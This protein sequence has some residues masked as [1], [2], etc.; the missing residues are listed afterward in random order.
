MGKPCVEQIEPGFTK[1]A[2]DQL[3]T[4]ELTGRFQTEI[5]VEAP[6]FPDI[7]ECHCRRGGRYA[8][9]LAQTIDG[10]LRSTLGSQELAD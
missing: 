2:P 1:G 3:G 9:G 8:G 10:D 6:P 7:A 5:R 4:V